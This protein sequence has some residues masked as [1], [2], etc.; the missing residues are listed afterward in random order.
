MMGKPTFLDTASIEVG[1]KAFDRIAERS[2]D[3]EAKR[4]AAETE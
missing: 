4:F 2:L 1:W 3:L